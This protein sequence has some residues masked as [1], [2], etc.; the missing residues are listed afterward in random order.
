MHARQS[1]LQGKPDQIEAG[2]KNF[3]QQ[4]LPA[5]Q[6][7]FQLSYSPTVSCSIRASDCLSALTITLA[8][9]ITEPEFQSSLERVITCGRCPD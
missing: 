1:T 8:E 4:I 5:I 3:N 7:L 2:I 6:T 9:T